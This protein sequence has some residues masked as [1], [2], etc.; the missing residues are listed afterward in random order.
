[1][2]DNALSLIIA[3]S[4]SVIFFP[5]TWLIFYVAFSIMALGEP[6]DVF[7]AAGYFAVVAMII[8]TAAV[9]IGNRF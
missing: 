5:L 1:M 9:A 6:A 8:P 7:K 2:N 4:L 3:G